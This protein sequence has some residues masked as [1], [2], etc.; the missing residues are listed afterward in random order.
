[1]L[2]RG[3]KSADFG[4][5]VT[6]FGKALSEIEQTPSEI[7]LPVPTSADFGSHDYCYEKNSME[8]QLN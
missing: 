8:V 4:V 5:P 6:E 7:A 1:L 3:P 2:L